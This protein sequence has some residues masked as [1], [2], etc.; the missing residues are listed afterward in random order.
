MV[1]LWYDA[2][3][4]T[5][6]IDLLEHNGSGWVKQL[7]KDFQTKA[8]DVDGKVMQLLLKMEIFG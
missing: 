5:F 1:Q 7:T 4:S 2:D 6:N 8:T 3:I